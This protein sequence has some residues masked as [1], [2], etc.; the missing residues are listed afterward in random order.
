MTL[1]YNLGY[2][3]IDVTN[4]TPPRSPLIEEFTLPDGS[5]ALEAPVYDLNLFYKCDGSAGTWQP[6]DDISV[7]GALQQLINSMNSV[8]AGAAAAVA[9]LPEHKE[10]SAAVKIARNAL[11]AASPNFFGKTPKG[12]AFKNGFVK[13]NNQNIA[14]LHKHHPDNGARFTTSYDFVSMVTPRWDTMLELVFANDPDKNEKIQLLHEFIGAALLGI[15]PRFGKCL[16]LY[17]DG[18]NG[19]STIQAVIRALFPDSVACTSNPQ[20][21]HKE[22]DRAELRGKRINITSELPEREMMES[23]A[24]KAIVEGAMI[25][26]RIIRQAP[27][28]FPPEAAHI[29]ACNMLMRTNDLT[30]GFYRRFLIVPFNNVFKPTATDIL[31]PILIEELGGIAHRSI[32]AV[33]GALAVGHLT[34]P[35]SSLETIAEW[36]ETANPVAA[37]VGGCTKAVV[38]SGEY[39]KADELWRAWCSWCGDTGHQKGTLTSFGRKLTLTIG[40]DKKSRRSDG[41]YD[42]LALNIEG[43]RLL[44]AYVRMTA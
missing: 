18:S 16:I 24:F 22:Y 8:T 31:T 11:W 41:V 9:V 39:T 17:G 33:E 5:K 21:W 13:L 32:K 4:T 6:I 35:S 40:S 25:S 15:A 19:K 36:K 42:G 26:A 38:S 43:N 7:H 3:L 23:E 1:E 2:R 20:T 44:Q 37:F 12:M 29:F 27:F 30:P 14:E 10:I 28:Q 34:T